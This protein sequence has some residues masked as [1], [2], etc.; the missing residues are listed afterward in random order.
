MKYVW[1]ELYWFLKLNFMYY[2]FFLT[3]SKSWS[4][5]FSWRRERMEDDWWLLQEDAHAWC[6]T[7]ARDWITRMIYNLSS[8]NFKVHVSVLK[9]TI[10]LHFQENL[11]FILQDNKTDICIQSTF[12]KIMYAFFIFSLPQIIIA[13]K[14]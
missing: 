11:S 4:Q 8:L 12:F 6:A 9:V 14:L 3:V 10:C 2:G 5:R 7:L 1:K 13:L